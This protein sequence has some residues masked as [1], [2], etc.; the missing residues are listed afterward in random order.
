MRTRR[1]LRLAPVAAPH[2]QRSIGLVHGRVHRLVAAQHDPAQADR[3][4]A[5]AG[6]PDLLQPALALGITRPRDQTVHSR[7]IQLLDGRDGHRQD[8]TPAASMRHHTAH[9]PRTPA[10]PRLLTAASAS[11]GLTR[12]PC[13]HRRIQAF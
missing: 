12:R 5:R 7:R 1:T 9:T 13:V 3:M 8:P 11:P 6:P 4:T 10:S 2:H